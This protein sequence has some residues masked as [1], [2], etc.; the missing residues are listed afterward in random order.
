[1]GF[2]MFILGACLVWNTSLYPVSNWGC[3]QKLVNYSD[4]IYEKDLVFIGT[5]RS[6]FMIVQGGSVQSL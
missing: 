1:M 2:N 4:S 6:E 3:V 5:G